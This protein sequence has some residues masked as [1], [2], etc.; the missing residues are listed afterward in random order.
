[1]KVLLFISFSVLLFSGC[2]SQAKYTTL[3]LEK[4]KTEAK[5]EKLNKKLDDLNIYQKHLQDSLIKMR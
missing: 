5:T 1:M 2:V 4:N 3:R